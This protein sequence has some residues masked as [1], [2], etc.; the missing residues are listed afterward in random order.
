MRTKI[1]N[2][3]VVHQEPIKQQQD[4]DHKEEHPLASLMK[5]MKVESNNDLNG[6]PK[7]K[8]EANDSNNP[9]ASLKE[10]FSDL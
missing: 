10:N 5:E 4:Q 7:E 6:E 2:F 9:M 8:S 3:T 1:S